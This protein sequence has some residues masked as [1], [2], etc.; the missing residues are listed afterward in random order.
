[1]FYKTFSLLFIKLLRKKN[2]RSRF[3]TKQD[4]SLAYT[5]C[6]RGTVLTEQL[7]PLLDIIGRPWARALPVV[8]LI[9]VL[10]VTLK[11]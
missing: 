8:V 2:T 6:L 11:K 1:M 4:S 3:L 9:V 7:S 10:I 5:L